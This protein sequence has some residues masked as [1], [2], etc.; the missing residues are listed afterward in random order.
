MSRSIH[1]TVKK[2]A[3]TNTKAS[4]TPDNPDLVALAQKTRYKSSKREKRAED[5]LAPQT[6]VRGRSRTPRV[7]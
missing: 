5:V 2:V 1:Q 6:G 7:R 4:L 3:K